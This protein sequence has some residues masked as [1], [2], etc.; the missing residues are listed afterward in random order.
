MTNPVFSF[1][2]SMDFT[3]KKVSAFWTFYDHDEKVNS[4][5]KAEAKN[6]H[7][8]A[9]LPLPRSLTGNRQKTDKAVDQ[10]IRTLQEA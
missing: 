7:Y 3:D 9:G 2:R 6:A 4:D 10:W 8:V 5:M 1:M